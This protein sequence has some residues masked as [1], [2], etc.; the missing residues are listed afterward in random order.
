MTDKEKEQREQFDKAA[1]AQAQQ[2]QEFVR[3]QQEEQMEAQAALMRAQR[4]AMEVQQEIN[5]RP[6]R[7]YA[8]IVAVDLYGGFS[9]EGQ[10]PWHYNA[11]FRWFQNK[12]KGHIC[13]M[14]RTTYDDINKR[15]GDKAAES[16]LPARTC[17]VVTSRPLPRAN[18]TAIASMT[19][20]D[21]LLDKQEIP[22]NK[23]VFYCGG[24]RIYQEAMSKVN[25]VYMTVVNKEIG[26]DKFF[27]MQALNKLKFSVADVHTEENEPDL[28]FV[29]YKR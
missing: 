5:A 10:I 3:R 16:V 4:Q 7:Q 17:F 13:V 2:Y 12:T 14:G 1:Q 8:S 6:V 25:T 18:A 21:F 20:L 23:T 22:Y 15:L 19:E 24:E 26:C 29:T 27:P 28:R 11:D 9:K